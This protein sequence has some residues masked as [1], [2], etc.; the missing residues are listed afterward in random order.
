MSALGELLKKTGSE[1]DD[2]NRTVIALGKE[3]ISLRGSLKEEIEAREKAQSIFEKQID[4]ISQSNNKLTQSNKDS[5]ICRLEKRHKDTQNLMLVRAMG[6]SFQ[7][8]LTKLFSGL[9]T[10]RYSFSCTFNIVRATVD[11]DT[12]QDQEPLDFCKNSSLLSR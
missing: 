11:K 9:F 7:H 5:A 2:Q 6:S 8:S 10:T 1:E 3:I 4:D 12:N